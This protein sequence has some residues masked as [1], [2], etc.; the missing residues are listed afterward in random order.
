MVSYP[1]YSLILSIINTE[2]G[3]KYGHG[4]F[5]CIFMIDSI[6]IESFFFSSLYLGLH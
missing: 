6:T 4:V 5:D 1:N 3:N 2:F